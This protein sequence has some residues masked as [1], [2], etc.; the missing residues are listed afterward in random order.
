MHEPKPERE[1]SPIVVKTIYWVCKTSTK[2]DPKVG[3]KT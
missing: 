2:R 1:D 3:G